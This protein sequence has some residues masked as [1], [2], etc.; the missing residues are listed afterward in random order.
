MRV[1][2]FV[3]VSAASCP[4]EITFIAIHWSS[5]FLW[6]FYCCSYSD[7]AITEIEENSRNMIQP[8][9]VKP[10]LITILR[11]PLSIAIKP[12]SIARNVTQSILL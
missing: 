11:K 3:S 7:C 1:T 9:K 12:L 8:F 6:I 5:H 10:L 2:T 4:P